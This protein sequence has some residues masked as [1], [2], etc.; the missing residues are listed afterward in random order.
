MDVMFIRA[1]DE[2]AARLA[3]VGLRFDL[4]EPAA[5]AMAP[6]APGS[7]PSKPPRLR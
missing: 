1:S 2:I 6:V 4:P 7:D 3:K 5:P